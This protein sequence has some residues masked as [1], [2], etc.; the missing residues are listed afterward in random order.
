V[1][2]VK[3][4]VVSGHLDWLSFLAGACVGVGCVGLAGALALWLGMRLSDA[5]LDRPKPGAPIMPEAAQPP[6]D[7]LDCLA[8]PGRLAY[9]RGVCQ[10]CYTQLRDLVRRHETTWDQLEAA[11]RCR[12]AMGTPWRR[13]GN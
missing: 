11:R 4:A 7:R 1:S 10:A 6:P 2:S 8:H 5:L 9:R 3:T 12:P 13:R